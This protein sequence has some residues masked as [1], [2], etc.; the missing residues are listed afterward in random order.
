MKPS[1]MLQF[2]W[3]LNGRR[4]LDAPLPQQ[5]CVLTRPASSTTLRSYPPLPRDPQVKIAFFA[6]KN[7]TDEE[8]LMR[9]IYK[10]RWCVPSRG[11]KGFFDTPS[12]GA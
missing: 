6:N 1:S 7:I 2:Q 8:E 5:H 11:Q 3:V 9:A 12:D 4:S 10:G